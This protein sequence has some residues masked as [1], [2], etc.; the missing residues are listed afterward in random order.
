MGKKIMVP[1]LAICMALALIFAGC[2]AKVRSGE[3]AVSGSQKI[4][5]TD[6]AGRKVVLDAPAKRVVAIGAGSLRLYCYI[7]GMKNVVGVENI[8]K[9]SPVGRPYLLANPGLKNLPT[10]G[11]GGPNSAPDPEKLIAVKPD[12][13][14]A[15]YLVDKA[16][17]DALQVKTGIP[18]VVLS[19]GQVATFDKNVYRSLQLIG[20]LIGKE[21]RAEEVVNFLEQCRKDL[22]ERVKNIPDARKPG[23]YIGALGMAGAHG[24]ESTQGKYAPFEAVQ[25]RNVVDETGKT[26]SLFIDKEKLIKW[27]PDIVF[28]DESGLGLVRQDYQK[29]PGF[30]R[31]ISAFQKG[32]VYAQLPYNWYT[33]NVDTAVAD[34][35]YAGKVIYPECFKDVD[36]VKK[37]DQIYI[38]LLGKPVYARMARDFGGF[39][40]ISLE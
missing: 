25:A 32:E 26:G 13:I 9:T 2:S 12:V 21:K 39:K 5:V 33:T 11:A 17:A 1:L 31:S 23:V 10:I 4:T 38:F 3:K 35:Y 16:S 29:N 15:S 7:N 37:A 14:L 27:N 24:I 18:V 19:Y 36:P 40:R 8:E 28:I 20:S 30:Y 6:L 34:A 22:A